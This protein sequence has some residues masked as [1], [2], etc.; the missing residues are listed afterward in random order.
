MLRDDIKTQLPTKTN[1]ITTITQLISISQPNDVAWIHYS[2]HGTQ[3]QDKNA[4]ETDRK[5]E[6]IIPCDYNVAGFITDDELFAIIKNAKCKLMIYFDSCNSGTACDLQYSMNYNPTGSISTSVNG[7]RSIANSNIIM[8]SGCRD[9]QTSADA[10]DSMAKQSVGAFTQTLLES[11]RSF[12][13]NIDILSL[14][15]KVCAT[16]SNYKFTQIPVLSSSVSSPTYQF[17]RSNLDES[18]VANNTLKRSFDDLVVRT[19]MLN[20]SSKTVLSQRMNA[21]IGK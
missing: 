11:L 5:D 18:S 21:L 8:L 15:K 3:I 7:S 20:I 19:P 10:Y 6:C 16:L 9:P 1:I 2:G 12:D 13:H 14:Y 17:I 4:D